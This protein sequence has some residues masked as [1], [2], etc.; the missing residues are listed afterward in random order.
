MPYFRF[1]LAI[2]L[3]S[4]ITAYASPVQAT[5]PTSITTTNQMTEIDADELEFDVDLYFESIQNTEEATECSGGRGRGNC[6]ST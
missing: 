1:A 5:V 2:A 3:L 4:T 6:F